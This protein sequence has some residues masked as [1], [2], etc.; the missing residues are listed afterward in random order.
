MTFLIPI[1]IVSF[2]D[3]YAA[4][5]AFINALVTEFSE[6]DP[7]ATQRSLNLFDEYVS[8]EA[9]FVK[10]SAKNPVRRHELPE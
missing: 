1:G 5:I 2:V 3:A 6:R 9:L 8:R 7:D 10:S 4:P